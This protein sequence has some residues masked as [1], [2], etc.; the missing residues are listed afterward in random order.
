VLQGSWSLPSDET[1]QSTEGG[2]L[3]CNECREI[4]FELFASQSTTTVTILI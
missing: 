2:I 4:Y 3:L 1:E